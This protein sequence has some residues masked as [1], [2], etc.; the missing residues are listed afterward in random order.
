MLLALLVL[1]ALPQFLGSYL[2]TVFIF[3][4]FYAYLGQAWNLLGGYG[5]Q[6]SL[7]HAAFVGIGAY[8]STYLAMTY[9][10]SPWIGM[11]IGG[12]AADRKS[13]V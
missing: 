6:I 5:G 9:K 8:T 7:G 1:L 12:A 4:F 13:V 3:I 2:L 11:L 10:L